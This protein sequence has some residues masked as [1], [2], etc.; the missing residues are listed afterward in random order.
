MTGERMFN[1]LDLEANERGFVPFVEDVAEKDEFKEALNAINNLTEQEKEI[2][3]ALAVDWAYC[4]GR[5][6]F[7]TGFDG[8]TKV[9]RPAATDRLKMN[10]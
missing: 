3:Y 10:A 1:L 5:E 4:V 9:S 8:I 6:A 7:V 2:I